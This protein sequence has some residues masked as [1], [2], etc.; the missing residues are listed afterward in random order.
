LKIAKKKTGRSFT[1]HLAFPFNPSDADFDELWAFNLVNKTWTLM[2][3]KPDP[4]VSLAEEDSGLS[5]SNSPGKRYLLASV[6]V[7][8]QLIIYGGN[9]QGQGDVWALDLTPRVSA[10]KSSR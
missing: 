3:V 1:R 6:V 9:R 2:Q 4:S 7:D 5:Q 10:F 8:G